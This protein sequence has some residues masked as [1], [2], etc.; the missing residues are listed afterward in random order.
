MIQFFFRQFPDTVSLPFLSK[1]SVLFL[2]LSVKSPG[3][4]FSHRITEPKRCRHLSFPA[5][6]ASMSSAS[7]LYGGHSAAAASLAATLQSPALPSIQQ[8][9][10]GKHDD[11]Y[12]DGC[13]SPGETLPNDCTL[14]R[15]LRPTPYSLAGA[16]VAQKLSALS[17]K[18]EGFHQELDLSR[19]QRK[20]DDQRKILSLQTQLNAVRD[21]LALESRNRTAGMKALQGVR[22]ARSRGSVD[23][24]FL[25]MF[26]F[27]LF[28]SLPFHATHPIPPIPHTALRSGWT[29]RSPS[30]DARWRPHSSARSRR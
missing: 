15:F 26:P 27:T 24:D 7:M 12:A 20:Q 5:E 18:F 3:I 4:R 2:I 21:S 1:K 23:R 19:N 6:W 14:F 9:D 8:Q 10:K 29:T 13:S 22:I 17:A 11:V 28:P 16:T 30:G 25:C